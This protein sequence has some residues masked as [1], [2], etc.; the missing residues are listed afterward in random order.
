MRSIRWALLSAAAGLM[1][2]QMIPA[3]QA[4]PP[5]HRGMDKQIAEAKSGAD[6]EAIAARY[7]RQAEIADAKVKRHEEMGA[8]YRKLGG[9]SVMKWHLDEHCDKLAKS[10]R[11]VAE[12]NQALAKAHR[13]MGKAAK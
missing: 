11:G 12:E 10:Y 8:S 7:E 1:I 3:A 13:E 5:A 2:L 4:G 6:H 9:P